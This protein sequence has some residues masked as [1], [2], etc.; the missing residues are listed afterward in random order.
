MMQNNQ[1]KKP[2]ETLIIRSTLAQEDDKLI[3]LARKNSPSSA[4]QLAVLDG[5]TVD[6]AKACRYL[7]MI[8][9]DYGKREFEKAIK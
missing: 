5:Y 7:A 9:R 3:H 1:S 8:L 2:L 6:E 4:Y